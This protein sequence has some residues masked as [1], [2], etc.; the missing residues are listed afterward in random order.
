MSVYQDFNTFPTLSEV[1]PSLVF[2]PKREALRH[3]GLLVKDKFAI[4]NPTIGDTDPMTG[5]P[6]GEVMQVV[7]KSH[8]ATPYDVMWDSTR[9]GILLSG[10]D[11]SQMQIKFII[12]PDGGSYSGDIMKT[13]FRGRAGGSAMPPAEAGRSAAHLKRQGASATQ[14]ERELR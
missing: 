3:N 8:V 4:I 6:R 5:Q 1:A 2:E 13:R 12:S 14:A 10:L 9:E 11:T 7:G